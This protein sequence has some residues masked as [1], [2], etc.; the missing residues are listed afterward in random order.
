MWLM[1]SYATRVQTSM[2][3]NESGQS[4]RTAS[5]NVSLDVGIFGNC[6]SERCSAS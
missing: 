6:I 5:V 3:I 4:L 2:V 1:E